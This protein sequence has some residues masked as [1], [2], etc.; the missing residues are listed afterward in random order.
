[1]NTHITN[2]KG[3]WQE[4]QDASGYSVNRDGQIRNDKTGKILKPFG[5]RGKYLGV[6]LGR[7]GYRRVHRIVAETFIPN[8]ENKPQVNHIDGDKANNRVENLE[9]CTLSENQRHR[10]DVLDKHFSREKMEA[11]TELA[12]IKNRKKV[13]CDDT[14]EIYSSIRAASVATGI[15]RANISNCAHGQYKQACGQH[16]SF[17]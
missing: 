14:G 2:I 12:A 8:P 15:S 17:V 5:S 4:I 1:M 7:A 3:N 16:W 11:I 9:W 10:F 13:R 6:G